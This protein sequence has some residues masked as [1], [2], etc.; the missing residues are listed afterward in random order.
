MIGLSL[1]LFGERCLFSVRSTTD[2]CCMPPQAHN[3]SPMHFWLLTADVRIAV[4]LLCPT[5]TINLDSD[6]SSKPLSPLEVAAMSAADLTEAFVLPFQVI[7]FPG[8]VMKEVS[9]VLG[10]CVVE[11]GSK[12]CDW[13]R[14][15][16]FDR[17]WGEAVMPEDL[18][19]QV[20]CCIHVVSDGR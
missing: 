2:T 7:L 12:K 14:I 11:N 10:A 18:R 6:A 13:F 5:H 3:E 1:A 9:K 17:L 4:L 20:Q 8:I 16:Q 15:V 19:A